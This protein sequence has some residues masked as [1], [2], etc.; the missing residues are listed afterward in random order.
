LKNNK[1]LTKEEI[2]R[3]NKYQNS[4]NEILQMLG[5]MQ[6]VSNPTNGEIYYKFDQ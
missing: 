2:D 5:E 3:E 4:L 6:K 1:K